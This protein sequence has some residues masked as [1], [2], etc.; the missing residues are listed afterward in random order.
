MRRRGNGQPRRRAKN[1]GI[2][3]CLGFA[4]K[5]VETS[6]DENLEKRG[7]RSKGY[8]LDHVALAHSRG[9]QQWMPIRWCVVVGW[10]DEGWWM[11]L[12]SP[13]SAFSLPRSSYLLYLF[14]RGR[15][16]RN[17]Q[18]HGLNR[19]G[20]GEGPDRGARFSVGYVQYVIHFQVR[21]S[22]FL[23]LLAIFSWLDI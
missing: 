4:A 23:P 5:T 20:A 10:F 7:P 17:E 22:L 2:R 3:F 21:R 16:R 8:P 19:T 13:D 15:S 14:P 9:I 18:N 12:E 6:R 1:G 11:L